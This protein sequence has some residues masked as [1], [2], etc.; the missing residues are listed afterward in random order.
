MGLA[1]RRVDG[2]GSENGDEPRR[3]QSAASGLIVRSVA[4]RTRGYRGAP[5][6]AGAAFL[7]RGEIRASEALRSSAWTRPGMAMPAL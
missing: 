4:G 1:A 3:S 2:L 7:E 5:A 6:A